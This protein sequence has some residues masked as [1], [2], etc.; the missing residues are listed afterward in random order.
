M[1]SEHDDEQ[2]VN[3]DCQ[4]H[5]VEVAGLLGSL[6][7]DKDNSKHVEDDAMV[8]R[9]DPTLERAESEEFLSRPNLVDAIAVFYFFL[10]DSLLMVLR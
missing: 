4:S 3:G 10:L 5:V 9:A 7:G 6:D 1:H 8:N 2:S